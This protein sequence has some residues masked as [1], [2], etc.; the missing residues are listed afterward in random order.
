MNNVDLG[1]QYKKIIQFFWD[2]EPKNDDSEQPIWCLGCEYRQ[3]ETPCPAQSSGE[4]AD[5]TNR[6]LASTSTS[7]TTTSTTTDTTEKR[8]STDGPPTP[9]S[10]ISSFVNLA[11]PISSS[12]A[13]SST[14][15]WPP[16]FLDDFESKL[17][18]TYRSQFPPI[19]KTPKT[20]S[21]DSSIS[22]GVRLR[23]QLIDTQGFTS[24]TGWGC[25]IRSGQALLANTLLFIRLG[26]GM[27]F[28]SFFI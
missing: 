8:T 26:R 10:A 16:Q 20:G 2:P 12:M 28:L 9:G 14:P 25:M 17:W 11:S 24:D 27:F 23:S 7:T 1:N 4:P 3:A 15:A 22:L 5:I 21:G 19:P 6:D 18:I 13:E